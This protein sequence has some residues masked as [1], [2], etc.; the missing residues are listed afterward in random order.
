VRAVSCDEFFVGDGVHNNILKSDEVVTHITL[1]AATRGQ[2][3]AYRKLRPR[4]AIDF[5][6][7]SI[8]V[9]ARGSA[10][11]IEALRI[12]V[13]AL[14]AK[15]RLLGQLDGYVGNA[16]SAETFAAIAAAAAKQCRPLTNVPFDEDWRHAMVPVL[17]QRALADAFAEPA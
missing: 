3:G 11:R 13:S 8:A 7:L 9:A 1:P 17:V 6:M 4:Q 2:C 16:A 15:P 14:G 10:T 5:P 12:V